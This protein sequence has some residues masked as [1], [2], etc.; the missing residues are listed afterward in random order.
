M[1][2]PPPRATRTD[3]LFPDTTLFRSLA[4][5]DLRPR[6]QGQPGGEVLLAR[7]GAQVGA[8]FGEYGQH[9]ALAHPVDLGQ[10]HPRQAVQERAGLEREAVLAV[11]LRLARGRQRRRFPA[12][13]AVAAVE[14]V[15]MPRSEVQ[16]S[17]LQSLM[18]I[19]YAA[20]WLKQQ[21]Q[22]VINKAT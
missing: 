19:S 4:A 11:S 2:R 8:G 22:L 6:A 5:G 10:I 16:P 20:F 7:P 9:G 21:T 14:P 15:Q 18:R 12:V 3:T 17:E 1:I 13:A